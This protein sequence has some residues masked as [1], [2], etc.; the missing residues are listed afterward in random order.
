M[1]RGGNS[2]DFLFGLQQIAPFIRLIGER[3]RKWNR[4]TNKQLTSASNGTNSLTFEYNEDG[5]RQKK[6]CNNIS[7][8][9]YY[10]GSVLI[11]M[12]RGQTK[13]LFS[14]DAGGNVVSVKQGNNEYY[15]LRNAQGDI[16]KI[17][18]AT[19]T[20]VVEYTYDTWGKKV[21]TTGSLAGTLGLFQ[22]FRYRGYVYDWETGFYYLQSRYYDPTV[23]RFISADVLLSTG[24]GVLGHNCYA[25]C[26]GNPVNMTDDGGCAARDLTQVSAE[27]AAGYPVPDP[28]K[29]IVLTLPEFE[30]DSLRCIHKK[31]GC[32]K[33]DMRVITFSSSDEFEKEWE[34]LCNP[35]VIVIINAHGS[36]SSIGFSYDGF[37]TKEQVFSLKCA[38]MKSLVLL[39][40][41][42]GRIDDAS[43]NIANAF[44]SIVDVPVYAA[45][46]KVQ[47]K[48]YWS[49]EGD[50]D[51]GWYAYRGDNGNF[52][53]AGDGYLNWE[54][55]YETH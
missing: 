32:S 11:G 44:A 36:S 1:I 5:L 50:M 8:D 53:F 17:I 51:K 4:E 18:D 49:H 21:T 54:D 3:S 30:N 38:P 27:G 29:V 19:G 34:K 42:C 43:D 48:S 10:N 37:V 55:I 46:G 9:Y 13:Y 22:P 52:S 6:I 39:C 20:S 33:S 35:S 2:S 14:Y 12:Q 26:L 23:G 40:C 15:Y 45:D 16:V 25:Y 24:Q 28:P 47:S 41:D 31:L 7:T